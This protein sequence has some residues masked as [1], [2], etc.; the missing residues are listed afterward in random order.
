MA[1]TNKDNK[2][3][4]KPTWIYLEEIIQMSLIAFSDRGTWLNE[5]KELAGVMHFDMIAQ[6]I[7]LANGGNTV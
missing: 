5:N 1:N 6:S 3:I 7:I 4:E 2:A